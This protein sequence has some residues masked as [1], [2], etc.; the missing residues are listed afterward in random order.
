M[1]RFAMP[2]RAEINF[3]PERDRECHGSFLSAW[4]PSDTTSTALSNFA[5]D[6]NFRQMI[7]SIVQGPVWAIVGLDAPIICVFRSPAI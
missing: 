1:L 7:I 4:Y 6:P 3:Q 5:A 2:S